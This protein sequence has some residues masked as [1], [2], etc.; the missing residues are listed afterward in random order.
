[1][2]GT[3]LARRTIGVL[4]IFAVFFLAASLLTFTPADVA[5][6]VYGS[7]QSGVRNLCGPMGA[8]IA[9]GLLR[10]FG[11]GAYVIVILLAGWGLAF[12]F[13]CEI[14]D[15]WL[16]VVGSVLLVVSFGSLTALP[17]SGSLVS[18]PT[19]NGG[20][21]GEFLAG[22]LRRS[23]SVAGGYLVLVPAVVVA[24]ILVNDRLV[25]HGAWR[26]VRLIGAL[27]ARRE[28]GLFRPAVSVVTGGGTATAPDAVREPSAPEPKR[29]RRKRKE[30]APADEPAP[31]TDGEPAD[32]RGEI[33]IR[34]A[35]PPEKPKPA[36]KPAPAFNADL[37]APGADYE[38]PPA[39]LLDEP[40]YAFNDEAE[41]NIRANAATLEK[42]L[43]EFGIEIQVVACETGPVITLYEVELSPGTRVQK[44]FALANDI[45]I[46]LKA[47][48]IR[49]VAP[50]PGKDTIGIE[51]PNQAKETVRLRE[52]LECEQA[53][54][55]RFR[56]PLFLGKDA[57]GEPLIF[58]L[59]AMPHLLI[60]GRTGSGKSVCINAAILSVLFT[61]T[62]DEV[63][64]LLVDP[65]M[66]ELS[67]FKRIPHLIS[68]VVTDMK[69]AAAVLQWAVMKMEERYDLLS[70]AG[71]RDIAGYN[72]LGADGLDERFAELPDQ[73]RGRIPNHLPYLVILVDELA[74]LMLIAGKDVEHA[75]TRLAQKSRSVGIHIVLATQRPSAD[76]ITGLIKANLPSRIAFQVSS[77]LESR[78]IV[79]QNGAETLLGA[80][81]MLFL[82]PSSADLTRAQ[83][84]FV[85]D[86]EI[87]RVVAHI[88][89]GG[90]KPQFSSELMTVRTDVETSSNRLK[91]YQ[92]DMYEP[93][94]RVVLEAQRGSVSLIQR[95]LGLG[96]GR[97]ARLID[98]MAEDGIV[99]DYQGSQ[100]RE[101]LMALEAWEAAQA[102][103]NAEPQ[104]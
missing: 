30:D 77:K 75:V 86:A 104:A 56:I 14:T 50:I 26:L 44:I 13:N 102:E 73:E 78:I 68:P 33:P 40:A 53:Q 96:Y 35:R 3:N 95:R 34:A 5:D 49:V 57:G 48:P 20:F 4:L 82:G 42:T 18:L 69:K 89:E 67:A 36:E 37:D 29:R 93:A 25:V 8:R 51:V 62:P 64:L 47:P 38:L 91:N 21:F 61:K 101:C 7:D 76:V 17:G 52:L 45:S 103:G 85:D 16:R 54:R 87:K 43:R 81:D 70:R 100:A 90:G 59:T 92:D 88:K 10:W 46:A 32:R 99:G 22:H 24:L 98:M 6:E 94:V 9:F 55:R 27:I 31:K 39:A 58:D 83:G 71:V 72:R 63:K 74:D 15:A 12:V 65:K 2:E 60:A 19:G 23:V 1:M 80:G 97:A 84:T 66:V 28:G 79:D 41:Q 11:L